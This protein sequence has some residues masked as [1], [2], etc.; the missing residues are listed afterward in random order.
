MADVQEVTIDSCQLLNPLLFDLKNGQDWKM[1]EWTDIKAFADQ[2]MQ[3][4]IKLIRE[5][6]PAA[7]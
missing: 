7:E 5:E 6:A 1:K 2:N 3:K 4:Y